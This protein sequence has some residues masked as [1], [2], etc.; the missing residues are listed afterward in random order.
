M[1]AQ[2][3]WFHRLDEI[4]EDLRALQVSHLDRLAVQKL[5]GV[6]E[7]R[8]R[9]LIAGLPGLQAGN[10]FAADRLALLARFENIV[11]GKPF[12]WESARRA[13]LVE[14]LEFTRRQLAG[15]RVRIAAASPPRRL[16]DLPAGID[17]TPGELASPS[18]CRGTAASLF[19]LSP[20][21]AND[22]LT[23]PA[24]WNAPSVMNARHL[25]EAHVRALPGLRLTNQR[26]QFPAPLGSSVLR[27]RMV[28]V[29]DRDFNGR[30]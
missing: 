30:C 23:S 20:A 27:K 6:K 29:V 19:A 22:W 18:R 1:P 7:R 15:R 8:A 25:T 10:A 13:R 28:A 5:F 26:D 14:D 9:Q 16:P 21:M 11:A 17:L 4:L 12:Q 24:P 2:P 3:A